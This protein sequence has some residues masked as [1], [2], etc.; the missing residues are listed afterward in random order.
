MYSKQC[1]KCEWENENSNEMNDF[2]EHF[3]CPFTIPIDFSYSTIFPLS[4][5]SPLI[6]ARPLSHPHSLTLSNTDATFHNFIKRIVWVWNSS[7]HCFSIGSIPLVLWL[8]RTWVSETWLTSFYEGI[9]PRNVP[10]Q[11]ERECWRCVCM[12]VCVCVCFRLLL[13]FSCLNWEG[14]SKKK[15]ERLEPLKSFTSLV[16]VLACALA[17][18]SLPLASLLM[19][20]SVVGLVGLAWLGL[21][22]EHALCMHVPSSN[23]HI[24]VRT[25]EHCHHHRTI[26]SI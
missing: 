15:D 7:S 24:C 16:L 14:R 19:S 6:L 4:L 1:N 17:R 26:N 5:F 11:T 2:D 8:L 13:P 25:M 18:S 9:R 23:M 21:P 20:D 12:C 10:I 22:M 3:L